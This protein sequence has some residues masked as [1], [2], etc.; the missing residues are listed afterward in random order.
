MTIEQIIEVIQSNILSFYRFVMSHS[1]NSF[2]VITVKFY[3]L[4]NIR[5]EIL[6]Y[7]MSFI[8][9]MLLFAALACDSFR[10]LHPMDGLSEWGEKIH[11]GRVLI[12]DA[13]IYS[14]H[15]FYKTIVALVGGL[16]GSQ[17][18]IATL[19]CLGSY[20]N[21]IAVMIYAYAISTMDFEKKNAQAMFLGWSVFFSP[22]ALSF[23]QLSTEAI[24][25]YSVSI[26][27][28]VVGAILYK[29][30]NPF[31]SYF[32]LSIDYLI[33]KFFMI[34]FS[35]EVKIVDK[36]LLDGGIAQYISCIQIDVILIILLL[37]I[38]FAYTQITT[39]KKDWKLKR[40]G[41]MLS[42]FPAMLAGVIFVA[43]YTSV[44]PVTLIKEEP[45]YYNRRAT[46]VRK[47]T[48]VEP[49]QTTTKPTK[50]TEFGLDTPPNNDPYYVFV[51]TEDDYANIRTGIGTDH[52]VIMQ[53]PSGAEFEGTGNEGVASN[54]RTWY[55]LYLDDSKTSVGWASAKV[56]E[57][58]E[59]YPIDNMY[60]IWNGSQGSM[61]ELYSDGT[62]YYIDGG[63]PRGDGT[64]YVDNRSILRVNTSALD[65]E[66]YGVL[67][68]GYE[69][70]TVTMLADSSSW[71]DELFT[72]SGE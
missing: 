1:E 72:K 33:T 64:W 26:S 50:P 9:L 6:L 14:L 43:G 48:Y 42:V 69:S 7:Y 15:I 23:C 46:S 39:E 66:I 51:V 56:V 12:F 29:R 61:L 71:N 31:I 45:E 20:I 44:N 30:A 2:L 4:D 24:M 35:G 55:E 59:R 54:G 68:F 60:G 36:P 25:L 40:D 8:F 70:K 5:T 21:P 27:F 34:Y 62:C 58:Q 38:M 3:K 22:A 11:I 19:S 37:L 53:A 41:V 47:N 63:S 17:A 28:G 49:I 13:S 57:R 16:I 32:V 52:D 65:Y 10:L 67:Q 18:C